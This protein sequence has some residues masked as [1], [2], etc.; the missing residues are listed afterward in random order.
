MARW[1]QFAKTFRG[2]HRPVDGYRAEERYGK[3]IPVAKISPMDPRKMENAGTK[4]KIK[5]SVS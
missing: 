5:V 2:A 3:K 1:W 4:R